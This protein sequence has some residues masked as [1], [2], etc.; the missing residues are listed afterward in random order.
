MIHNRTTIGPFKELPPSG[1][2]SITSYQSQV[3]S[4]E[5][6]VESEERRANLNLKLQ[7]APRL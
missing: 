4:G 7:Q 1:I 5:R 3:K 2:H 6:R